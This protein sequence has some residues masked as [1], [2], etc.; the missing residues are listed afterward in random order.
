MRLSRAEKQSFVEAAGLAGLDLSSWVRM[1]LRDA[2]RKQLRQE[3][4]PVAFLEEARK[5]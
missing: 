5:S 4:R 3:D 2:A 1:S